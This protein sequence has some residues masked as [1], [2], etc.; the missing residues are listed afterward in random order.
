MLSI[1]RIILVVNG[2]VAVCA[3]SSI[4]VMSA[5]GGHGK[6]SEDVLVL[7]LLIVILEL[8]ELVE[9]SELSLEISRSHAAQ[10]SGLI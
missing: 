7:E 9:L 3:S 6:S 2:R 4:G 5:N 8:D 1:G 10:S